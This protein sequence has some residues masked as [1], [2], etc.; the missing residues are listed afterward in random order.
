MRIGRWKR[1]IAILAR[2]ALAALS[3]CAT[4]PVTAAA[5]DVPESR[6]QL[7]ADVFALPIAEG[8]CDLRPEVLET[9]PPWADIV[10]RLHPWGGAVLAAQVDC[11]GLDRLL[12]GSSE[13]PLDV[14]VVMLPTRNG[15]PL[16]ADDAALA[17]FHGMKSLTA[18]LP[19]EHRGQVFAVMR[20]FVQRRIVNNSR[21][22]ID[23]LEP[24]V[25]TADLGASLCGQS[26]GFGRAIP[27]RAGIAMRPEGEFFL[28]G[29]A[30]ALDSDRKTGFRDASGMLSDLQRVPRR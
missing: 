2:L 23:C 18:M 10:A 21:A 9:A 4:V 16:V 12:S 27:Y 28:A 24:E 6:F 22:T 13:G 7:G 26:Q 20:D 8:Q 3:A 25:S 19:P 11:A 15:A 29:I 14:R 30:L 5:G 1:R 17:Q